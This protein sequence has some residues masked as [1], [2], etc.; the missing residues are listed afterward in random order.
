VGGVLVVEVISAAYGDFR[1]DQV[2]VDDL[3]GPGYAR[4]DGV[5]EQRGVLSSG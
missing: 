4:M 2:A 3:A 1:R 5:L